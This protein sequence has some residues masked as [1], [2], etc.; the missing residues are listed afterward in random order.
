MNVSSA[1]YGHWDAYNS[2]LE[3]FLQCTNINC[4]ALTGL[5]LTVDAVSIENCGMEFN[6]APNSSVYRMQCTYYEKK[7]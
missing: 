6:I 2:V 7:L 5:L 3:F 4:T 1:G